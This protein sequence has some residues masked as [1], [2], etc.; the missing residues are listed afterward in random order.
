MLKTGKYLVL[1]FAL[2]LLVGGCLERNKKAKTGK[3]LD[4]ELAVETDQQKLKLLKRIDRKFE[5]PKAHYELGKLYQN[6]GLWDKAEWEY[7]RTLAFDPVN[8]KA[9]AAMVQ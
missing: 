1:L 6:E 4:K 5:D 7:N 3:A 8:Y 2:F 9:Q